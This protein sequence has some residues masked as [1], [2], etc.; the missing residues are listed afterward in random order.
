MLETVLVLKNAPAWQIG[1]LNLPGGKI[2]PGETP[3]EAAVRE[4]KEETGYDPLRGP[5]LLGEIRD[6]GSTIFCFH[7]MVGKTYQQLAPR[8]EETETINWHDLRF[9]LDDPRMIP[10]LR[11]IIPLMMARVGGWIITDDYRGSE[12]TSHKLEITVPTYYKKN[13]E[14]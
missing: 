1:R 3:L 14:Q 8:P 11:V 9:V 10:N 7:A 4:L 2:E 5:N 13:L 12:D 6:S